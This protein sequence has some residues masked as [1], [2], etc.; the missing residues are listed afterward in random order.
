LHKSAANFVEANSGMWHSA[1]APASE[2]TPM[3]VATAFTDE[4]LKE[5]RVTA[6]PLPYCLRERFLKMLGSRLF[7]GG[8]K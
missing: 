4:Q 5:L 7:R 2:M 6:G 1:A 3:P 8:Q